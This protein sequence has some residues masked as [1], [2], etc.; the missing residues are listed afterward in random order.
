M[1]VECIIKYQV[2]GLLDN[3]LEIQLLYQFNADQAVNKLRLVVVVVV[4]FTLLT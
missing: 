3:V 4:E 2:A 1:Y